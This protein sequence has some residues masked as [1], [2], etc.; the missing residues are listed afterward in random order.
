M[1]T[2]FTLFRTKAYVFAGKRSGISTAEGHA[3]VILSAKQM[4]FTK[5]QHL[6]TEGP[7]RRS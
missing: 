1:Y 4:H 6:G 3:E 2:I 7:T 5:M